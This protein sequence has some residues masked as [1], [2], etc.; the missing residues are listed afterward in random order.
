[1]SGIQFWVLPN[2]GVDTL[3][4]LKEHMAAYKR[5]H[6]G[7]RIDV[8]VRTPAGMWTDLFRMLKDPRRRP[9][10]DLLQIPSHWTSSLAH[11]GLLY[12][13]RDLDP[14][15]DLNRWSD[16]FRDHCRLAGTAEVR[17]FSK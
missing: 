7:S 9:R 10:P 2:S 17:T 13:L 8:R 5:E 14:Q 6:P 4:V 1:M 11:L 12:D 16:L 3:P 15:L